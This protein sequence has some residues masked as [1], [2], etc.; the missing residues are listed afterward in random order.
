M[1]LKPR[2]N[3]Q[4][5]NLVWSLHHFQ[6]K[7]AL[8]REWSSL[9]TLAA[10]A[11]S[12]SCNYFL[13]NSISRLIKHCQS[14]TCVCLLETIHFLSSRAH[15]NELGCRFIETTKFRTWLF[16][17]SAIILLNIFL[18]ETLFLSKGQHTTFRTSNCPSL[19]TLFNYFVSF[20]D[21]L[22]R[23]VSFGE[24]SIANVMTRDWRVRE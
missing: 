15:S 4:A 24:N 7:N 3:F 8:R 11:T 14:F 18:Q 16:F 20:H 17:F 21:H 9:S 10:G 22:T 1:F 2:T 5:Q 12:H 19:M 13:P 6:S 23:R